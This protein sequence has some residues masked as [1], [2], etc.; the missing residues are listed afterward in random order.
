MTENEKAIWVQDQCD[1][2]FLKKDNL[3][4]SKYRFMVYMEQKNPTPKS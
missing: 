3:T 2:E 4:L 1:S